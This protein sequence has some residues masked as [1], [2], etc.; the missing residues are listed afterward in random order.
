MDP[1][2]HAL[3]GRSLNC[4]D[5]RRRLG[6]GAAAAFVLGSLAP[7]I[8]IVLVVRGWDIYLQSH[9]LGT[10][11]VAAAPLLAAATAALVRRCVRGSRYPRLFVAALIGVIAG[12]V[13][14]DLVSG[15]NMRLLAPLSYRVYAPHLL[16]MADVTAMAVLLAGTLLSLWRRTAGGVVVVAGLAALLVVKTVSWQVASRTYERAALQ[17]AAVARPEAINGSLVRWWYYDRAGD[18]ARAWIVDAWRQQASIAFTRAA[19]S[20]PDIESTR[21]VPAVQRFFGLAEVPF[22]RVELLNGERRVLWSDLKYC[23]ADRC[24]MSFGAAMDER[25]SPQR[26]LIQIGT[27]LMTRPFEFRA[28]AMS[29]TCCGE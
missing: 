8:D 26:E 4:L 3:L 6:R 19:L 29:A 24:A 13:L 2:S 12:H 7:D 23:D 5:S 21:R 9:A 16:A 17:V 27:Y 1:I 18:V 11:T 20:D 22:A 10:H 15:S 28:R 25:G 14:F